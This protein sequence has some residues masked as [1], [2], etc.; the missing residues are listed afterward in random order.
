MTQS[1]LVNREIHLASRP[2]GEPVLGNFALVESAIPEPGEGQLLVRN[3]WMS[4]DPYMRGRMNAGTGSYIPPFELGAPL[5]GGATGTVVAS[6]ADAIPV[7]TTVLHQLGWREY[8]VVDAATVMPIDVSLAPA[9]AYLGVLGMPGLTA[10][11]GLVEVAPVAEGDVV[12]IS[13]AAGAVGSV[14]GQIARQLGASRV[15]GSAGGPEKAKKLVE[16][17]GFDAAI[18]YRAGSLADQLAQAAPEGIDVY[19]DN[20]GGD[21]LEA[22]ITAM[23]PGGRI[24]MC[25]AISQYNATEPT[26][27]PR[28]LALAIGK[29]LTL[30]GLLVGSYYHLAPEYARLAGGWLASGALRAEETVLDGIERAPEAFLGMMR[31]ANTGKML[32]RLD[33]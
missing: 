13:G 24:A 6:R 33:G 21:H 26:P 22:A 20:V 15:I 31:G 23:R 25:G 16:D 29:Q 2:T 12:F 11:A 5:S 3:T 17:F 28:N 8:S 27:G 10:Y 19:F 32:V 18:D 7:G 1:P 14:A 4:V 30:R 9:P